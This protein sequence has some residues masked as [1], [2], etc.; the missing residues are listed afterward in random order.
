LSRPFQRRVPDGKLFT[1]D[2]AVARMAA[3]LEAAGTDDSGKCLAWDG[4]EI[5]P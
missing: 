5:T 3:V 1:A 2:A 4:R